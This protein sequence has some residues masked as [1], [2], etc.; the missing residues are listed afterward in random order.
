MVR[1]EMP[2]PM[3]TT[4]RFHHRA[5]RSADWMLASH[6]VLRDHLCP[7]SRLWWRHVPSMPDG[8]WLPG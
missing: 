1:G 4:I 5:E 3:S 8:P 2:W 6:A 7:R